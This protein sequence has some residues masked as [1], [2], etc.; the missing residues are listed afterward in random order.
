MCI[1]LQQVMVVHVYHIR[2]L[3]ACDAAS[4]EIVEMDV[5]VQQVPGTKC[6]HKP[7]KAGKTPMSEVA[8]VVNTTR[9]YVSEQNIKEPPA[10][11]TIPD[12]LR[13]K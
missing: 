9:R 1:Y 11:H 3:V 2:I 10:K 12:Q 4:V 7:Q 8:L 6:S 5:P 13:N